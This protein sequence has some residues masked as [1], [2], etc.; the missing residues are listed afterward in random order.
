MDAQQDLAG[1]LVSRAL[2]DAPARRARCTPETSAGRGATAPGD[3]CAGEDKDGTHINIKSS[4]GLHA[5][6]TVACSCR[7]RRHVT[8]PDVQSLGR[9]VGSLLKQSSVRPPSPRRYNAK[10]RSR[11][12]PTAGARTCGA[13][14]AI[15]L[16]WM[17]TG[18]A[19]FASMQKSAALCASEHKRRRSTS[20]QLCSENCSRISRMFLARVR[21]V[22]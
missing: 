18:C 20:A 13:S 10:P 8:H 1:L 11:T 16:K 9:R 2:L 7:G 15:W 5:V 14:L 19:P 22:G 21:A 3:D 17:V 4:M 12:A 6:L